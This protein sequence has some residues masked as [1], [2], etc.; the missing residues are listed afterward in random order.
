MIRNKLAVVFAFLILSSVSAKAD[1]AATRQ[2]IDQLK[3]RIEQLEEKQQQ[4]GPSESN[5]G[6]N[7]AEEVSIGAVISGAYQYEWVSGPSNPGDLGRGAISIQPQ[8]SITPTA[9]DEIFLKFGFAAG[10]GLPGVTAFNLNPWAADLEDDVKNINGRNRD[11]LLTAWY[12][13]S[14]EFGEE[15]MLGLTGGLIDSTDYLDG[16]AYANDQYTQFMNEALLNAPNSLLPGYDI[17]AALQWDYRTFGV[18]GV[19]MNVGENDDGSNFNFFGAQLMVTLDS[20]RGE[21]HYRVILYST[22]EDFLDPAGTSNERRTALIFSFDQA[23][24]DVLGAWIRFAAQDDSAAVDYKRLYSGGINVSGRWWGREL[25]NLGIGY[26]YV[27]GAEQTPDSIRSSQ[28]AE[29][30]VNIGLNDYLS[31]ALDLQYMQDRY[32]PAASGD[33]VDGWIAGIRATAEF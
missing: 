20:S 29:A 28:V 4:T 1:D 24:G 27:A 23:F 8:V 16:N 19:T 30:Y 3:Q 22:S 10:N 33:D 18:S 25:D 17:G 7:I 32:L 15:H 26:A 11:Y 6:S 31:V 12:K 14:F 9:F 2:E 5:G 13:H 21:G